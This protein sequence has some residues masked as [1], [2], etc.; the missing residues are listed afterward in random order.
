MV[1]IFKTVLESEPHRTTLVGHFEQSYSPELPYYIQDFIR[2]EKEQTKEGAEEIFKK[3]FD[4][5]ALYLLD[6]ENG[7]GKRIKFLLSDFNSNRQLL[8]DMFHKYCIKAMGE[9]KNNYNPKPA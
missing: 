1:A 3:Y 8:Q 9:M 4:S 6:V 2:W 5:D 7:D